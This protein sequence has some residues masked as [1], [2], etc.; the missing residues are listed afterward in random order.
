MEYLQFSLTAL[1]LF[2]PSLLQG[3]EDTRHQRVP[4][5]ATL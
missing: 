1:G 2:N 4:R 5:L 3:Q